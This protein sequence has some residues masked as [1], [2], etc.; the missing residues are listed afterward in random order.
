MAA[1]LNSAR[2][3]GTLHS[4]IDAHFR[5]VNI[6]RTKDI[7]PSYV[8]R[9]EGFDKYNIQVQRSIQ[10]IGWMNALP[11]NPQSFCQDPIRRFY[12]NLQVVTTSPLQ[13]WTVVNGIEFTISPEF[14]GFIIPMELYGLILA[15]DYDLIAHGFNHISALQSMALTHFDDPV[16][17]K[18]S[19]LSD[20]LRVLHFMITRHFLPR[21]DARDE[22]TPLDI[23]ILYNSSITQHPICLPHLILR[24]MQSAA[25]PR[26]SASTKL[27][28][29]HTGEVGHKLE[30]LISSLTKYGNWELDEKDLKEASLQSKI[31]RLLKILRQRG[32]WDF[33]NIEELDLGEPEIAKET[34]AQL[35]E[36]VDKKDAMEDCSDYESDPQSEF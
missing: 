14:L 24:A 26:S 10:N 28:Y 13:L 12:A 8:F 21:S 17:P 33:E 32:D 19:C 23:W 27:Q 18:V 15:D 31:I 16:H 29:P 11:V 4:F 2:H 34:K 20:H 1:F 7:I 9:Y 5:Y 30:K 35:M 25:S 22:L 36:L 6:F 3:V